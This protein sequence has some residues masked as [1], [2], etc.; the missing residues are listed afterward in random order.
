MLP[1]DKHAYIQGLVDRGRTVVMVGDGVNDS[2]ALSAASV[3]VSMASGTAIAREVADI[4]L[5]TGDLAALV[6]LRRLSMGLGVRMDRLFR[7]VISLNSVLLIGGIGGAI[8][9]Q[10]SSLV[11]NAS[12]VFF[13][14]R[15]SRAYR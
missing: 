12:T 4:V 10:A 13:S 11:H 6:D 3:G 5:S 8:T 1:E 9:P 15:S 7:E 2:P 14:M